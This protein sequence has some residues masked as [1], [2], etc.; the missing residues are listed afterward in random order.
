MAKNRYT[1]EERV[2][3]VKEHLENGK[4]FSEIANSYNLST[5]LV[6][7]WVKK[8]WEMGLA[9]LE[10]RRGKRTAEQIPRTPHVRCCT[11]FTSVP[12]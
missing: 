10:D 1:L 2:Q 6:R 5:Q 11:R 3:V 9:G 7:T 4:S 12:Y 8:Y